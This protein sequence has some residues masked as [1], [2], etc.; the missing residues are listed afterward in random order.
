V[1]P[2]FLSIPEDAVTQFTTEA[3]FR[4][5]EI[6]FEFY[7]ATGPGGQN[8]NK[9]STA[10]RL[11]FDVRRS[12][13]LPEAVKERLAR[14]AGRRLTDAGVLVIEAQRFRT[15]ERNR[16][17]ELQRLLGMIQRAQEPPR[18]RRATRPTAGSR[19]RRLEAKRR[20]GAVKRERG[21]AA[22]Q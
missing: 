1:D 16:H 21:R 2:V 7:R 15:Q 5:K 9:V 20:R 17:E 11:R 3:L 4:A 18:P 6:Q 8:V 19:E 12:R 10:V 22:E 13:L 14:S